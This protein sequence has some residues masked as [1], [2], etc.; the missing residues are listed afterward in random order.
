MFRHQRALAYVLEVAAGGS[1]RAAAARLHIT[2]SALNRRIRDV[3][4]ELGA[5]LFERG[6]RGVRPT[7][8][9]AEFVRY[10]RAQVLEAER[11]RGRLDDL[12]GLRR[13]HV[14]IA[15]SQAAGYAFLPR[16]VARFRARHP[17]ATVAVE[18]ADHRQVLALLTGLEV[19]LALAYGGG[20]V[21]GVDV[22]AAAAQDL[23]VLLPTGHP[24]ADRWR[25]AVADLAGVALALPD[26]RFGSRALLDEAAAAAGVVLEVAAESNS[27]ET[28]RGLVREAGLAS[29]QIAIGTP[30]DGAGLVSRPLDLATAAAGTELRLCRLGD[31]PLSVAAAAFAHTL[32]EALGA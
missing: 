28:L 7:A 21:P 25:I 19:E 15:C 2:P 20:M 22:L 32:A 30:A 6:P 13:G 10:A 9:G 11:V 3:E 17:G 12:K 5:V 31:R 4:A 27:F 8:S 23:R 1:I 18:V 29:L 14:R 26:R 24:L 16:Q